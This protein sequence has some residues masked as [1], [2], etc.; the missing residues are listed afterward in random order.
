LEG[1]NRAYMLYNFKT[2]DQAIFIM[3]VDSDTGIYNHQFIPLKLDEEYFY[4]DN[5]LEKNGKVCVIC[6]DVRRQHPPDLEAP[7]ADVTILDQSHNKFMETAT[8]VKG[9]L[10][11]HPRIEPIPSSFIEKLEREFMGKINL[12]IICYAEELNDRNSIKLPC[13]H[14][15]CQSCVK[16]HLTSLINEAKVS[17]MKCLQAG[18]TSSIP[19]NVI[20]ENLDREIFAKYIRFKKRVVYYVNLN[21]GMIPCVSPDCEEWIMFREGNNPFVICELGHRFCAKCKKD[22]HKKGNCTNVISK[23]LIL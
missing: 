6:N 15:F 20:Q 22:W 5:M 9:L 3:G 4:D 7:I 16:T 23:S 8:P 21:N 18:C 2:L 11:N 12:C 19:D 10:G 14:Q 13:G 1:I 17:I